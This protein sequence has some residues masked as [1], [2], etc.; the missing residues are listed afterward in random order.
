MYICTMSSLICH[1]ENLKI[2]TY[3]LTDADFVFNLLNTD[4][5]IKYIGN[6]NILSLEDAENYISTKLLNND[7]DAFFGYFVVELKESN[8]PIGTVGILKRDYL[9]LPDLGFA[10]LA[11]FCGKGFAF[12]ASLALKNHFKSK[13]YI[14]TLSAITL[15]E[16]S[17]SINLLKKLDFKFEKTI[18]DPTGEELEYYSNSSTND[19]I[20]P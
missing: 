2:R 5:W 15:A 12:E 14:Q 1:S 20:Y 9:D 7:I 17:S 11:D 10:F 18:V 13:H 19:S 4:G 8:I 6:R 3:N 16:N